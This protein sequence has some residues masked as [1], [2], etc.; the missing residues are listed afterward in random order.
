MQVADYRKLLWARGESELCFHF[1]CSSVDEEMNK[2]GK[3]EEEQT[4]KNG[5]NIHYKR[6]MEGK[7]QV[8]D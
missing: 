1:M 8:R 3:D 4:Q 5:D 2:R 7:Q 6:L